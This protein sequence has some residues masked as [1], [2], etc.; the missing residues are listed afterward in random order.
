[1]MNLKS[2]WQ[3]V[4]KVEADLPNDAIIW[5]TST[6][7]LEEAGGR[8]GVVMDVPRAAAAQRIYE[9]THRLATEEEKAAGIADMERRTQEDLARERMRKTSDSRLMLTPELL[10][11]ITAKK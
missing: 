1:M 8:A 9:K 6:D 5:L 4:R 10:A 7:V 11:A 3:G 2:Y